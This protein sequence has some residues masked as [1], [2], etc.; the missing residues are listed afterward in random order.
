M[1]G[2]LSI[3]SQKNGARLACDLDEPIASGMVLIWSEVF[4][5]CVEGDRCIIRGWIWRV[6]A[7]LRVEV[8]E[9]CMG[10]KAA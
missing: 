6:F 2:C 1:T 4:G 7:F 9:V 10:G 8:C 3:K 5:S